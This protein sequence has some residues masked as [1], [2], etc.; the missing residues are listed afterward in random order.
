[1]ITLPGAGRAEAV[2]ELETP[3]EPNREGGEVKRETKQAEELEDEWNAMH[4]TNEES[5]WASLGTGDAEET[6]SGIPANAEIRGPAQVEEAIDFEKE[7]NE[8]HEDWEGEAD[9]WAGVARTMM[10]S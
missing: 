6:P 9:P 5:P 10:H 4:V 3:Q 2:W 7:W 1:M 8:L